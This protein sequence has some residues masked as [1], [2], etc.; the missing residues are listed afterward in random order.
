MEMKIER[1]G[2]GGGGSGGGARAE[3]PVVAMIMKVILTN[4]S[5]KKG[6]VMR[7]RESERERERV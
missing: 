2:G 5:C 6:A 4:V 3:Q 1:G 7:G